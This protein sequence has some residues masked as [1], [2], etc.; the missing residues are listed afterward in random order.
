LSMCFTRE[1]RLLQKL[2]FLSLCLGATFLQPASWRLHASILDLARSDYFMNLHVEWRPLQ[3]VS[4]EGTMFLFAFLWG[5]VASLC[6]VRREKGGAYFQ[7][8]LLV[9]FGIWSLR[10]VRILPFFAIVSAAPMALFLTMVA[11][12]VT[13]VIEK[14]FV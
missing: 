14:R 8:A 1:E 7:L 2:L 12:S 13:G 11:R 4:A 9:A 10:S 5:L 6:E 3:L